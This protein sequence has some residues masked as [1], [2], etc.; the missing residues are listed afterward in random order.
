MTSATLGRRLTLT[1]LTAATC[2]LTAC[3]SSRPDSGS[4]DPPDPEADP[5]TDAPTVRVMTYNV[6]RGLA[7]DEAGL[8]AIRRGDAD[9][10]FLQETNADWEEAI[11]RNFSGIFPHMHFDTC[12]L[13]GGT[14]HS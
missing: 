3:L 7:G 4:P 12:C 9:L 1:A 11:R 14:A 8:Q 5:P 6:N 13:S 10:V 2:L